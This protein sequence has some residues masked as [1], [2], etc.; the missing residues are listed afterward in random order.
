MESLDEERLITIMQTTVDV[1]LGQ[2]DEELISST[3]LDIDEHVRTRLISDLTTIFRRGM[4]LRLGLDAF[5]L[6][7]NKYF[8]EEKLLSKALHA[9]W[10]KNSTTFQQQYAHFCPIDNRLTDLKWVAKLPAESKYGTSETSPSIE[11]RFSTTQGDYNLTLTQSGLVNLL[12]ELQ[13][14]QNSIQSLK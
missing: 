1:V 13:N 14:I 3:L 7:I 8:A 9:F 11:C 10:K 4:A 6:E 5:D 12:D 2:K